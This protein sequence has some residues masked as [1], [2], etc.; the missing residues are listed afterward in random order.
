MVIRMSSA[1]LQDF[2]LFPEDVVR[3]CDP[4]RILPRFSG[5]PIGPPQ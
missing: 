1:L 5:L 4:I 2:V 3:L